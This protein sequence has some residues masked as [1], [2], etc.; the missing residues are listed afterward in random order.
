MTFRWILFEMQHRIWTLRHLKRL[1]EYWERERE[2][3]LKTI[4]SNGCLKMCFIKDICSFAV[5][6]HDKYAYVST[7]VGPLSSVKHSQ[8]R[9]CLHVPQSEPV[10]P[11]D[12]IFCIIAWSAARPP[13]R[14]SSQLFQSSRLP[15][16]SIFP[17][18]ECRRC[19]SWNGIL[20]ASVWLSFQTMQ[21]PPHLFILAGGAHLPYFNQTALFRCK[22]SCCDHIHTH[23]HTIYDSDSTHFRCNYNCPEAKEG[24]IFAI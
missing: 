16:P 23:T 24:L 12:I 18:S 14:P 20:W 15:S 13:L 3:E 2:G 7:P 5:P 8:L 21:C 6:H 11:D 19:F 10:A 17:K 1:L 4:A 22:H 9:F